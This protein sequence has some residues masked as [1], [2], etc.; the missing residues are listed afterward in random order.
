MRTIRRPTPQFLRD[1]KLPLRATAVFIVLLSVMGVTRTFDYL[2]LDDIL[3][4]ATSQGTDYASLL[5][6]DKTDELQKNNVEEETASAA[7]PEPSAPTVTTVNNTPQ[8]PATA[9]SGGTTTQDDDE[10]S[11]PSSGPF[12][13]DV[14]SFS[15][16]TAPSGPFPCSTSSGQLC[17]FYDLTAG[18]KSFNGPGTVRYRFAWRSSS[19]S[20][21]TEQGS[22]NAQSGEGFAKIDQRFTLSCNLAPGPYRFSFYTTDPTNDTLPELVVDHNCTTFVPPVT[23]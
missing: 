14:S 22:Y 19:N 17:K 9:P 8:T 2:A 12:T 21:N 3:G 4:D 15:F 23:P 6:S 5:S 16:K 11:T 1:Y 10:E 20:G 18:V 13:V 7:Q